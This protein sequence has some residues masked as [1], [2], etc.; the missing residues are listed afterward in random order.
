NGLKTIDEYA[1]QNC[2][3]LIKIVI[4]DSVENFGEWNGNSHIFEGCDKLKEVTIGNGVK[5]IKCYMFENCPMLE[6]VTL[7]S[8]VETIGNSAFSNCTALKD[9]YFLGNLPT[10]DTSGNANF[11]NANW[12]RLSSSTGL[13]KAS[14]SS[15]AKKVTINANGGIEATFTK[16]FDGGVITAP[17]NPTREGYT[18][19]GWYKNAD[20]TGNEFNFSKDIQTTDTT[21]FAKWQINTYRIFFDPRGGQ[22][23]T[24]GKAVIYGQPVGTLD[25]PVLAG[26]TF[27]GWHLGQNGAGPEYTKDTKMPAKDIYLYASWEK[28][29][30]ATTVV[31]DTQGGSFLTPINA[32]L[33]T[34]ISKPALIPVKSG[35]DFIGW[36]KD[37]D[38]NAKWNFATDKITANTTIYAHWKK[39]SGE[40]P[41][42]TPPTA[43]NSGTVTENSAQIS[44]NASEN[45]T[46][47]NVYVNGVLNNSDPIADTTYVVTNLSKNTK[48]AIVIKAV[49]SKGESAIGTSITITTKASTRML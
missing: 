29:N 4:P 31:F 45:A 6:K 36:Y 42:P 32:I 5:I 34:T 1:F 13:D 23:T 35:Y 20:G 14:L 16:D 8:S 47:Y 48:Y 25:V 44:W 12:Y 28:N 7:G 18:F 39:A 41:I 40:T 49:N 24:G 9:V 11:N 43:V 17:I 19:I 2:D 21:L 27:K 30:T 10:I 26:D 3:S 37:A 38:H 46:G 33:N 15:T 22:V